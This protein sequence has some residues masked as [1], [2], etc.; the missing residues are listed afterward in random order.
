MPSPASQRLLTKRQLNEVKGIPY[1]DTHLRRLWEAGK[2]PRPCKIG[3]R[4]L[5]WFEHEI[6]AWIAAQPRSGEARAV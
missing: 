1:Q 5:V 3:E 4:K 6:D 2:F